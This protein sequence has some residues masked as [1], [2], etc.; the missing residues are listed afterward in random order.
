MTRLRL[1]DD[2]LWTRRW[3][4]V[5]P[6]VVTD[7]RCTSVMAGTL[8]CKKWNTRRPIGK[9]QSTA[10]LGTSS[11]R[12][13]VLPLRLRATAVFNANTDW[14]KWLPLARAK[15]VARRRK[16]R[17]VVRRCKRSGTGKFVGLAWGL[18]RPT[19][20][21]RAPPLIPEQ[22]QTRTSTP[23]RPAKSARFVSAENSLWVARRAIHLRAGDYRTVTQL[24]E[25]GEVVVLAPDSAR[26][27]PGS[28]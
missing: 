12:R 20:C 21:N 26:L 10:T 9:R 25:A 18:L 14:P 3:S 16:P 28:S 15:M 24:S 17:L 22:P 6:A 13:C 1:R 27:G 4:A 23:Q 2:R 7:R 5:V 11:L 19:V 8:R